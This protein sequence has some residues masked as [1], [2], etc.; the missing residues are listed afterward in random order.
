MYLVVDEA[1]TVARSAVKRR[2]ENVQ[3]GVDENLKIPREVA[4]DEVAAFDGGEGHLG[5]VHFRA[6]RQ[7]GDTGR[8]NAQLLRF[9]IVHTNW[10][11]SQHSQ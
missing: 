5:G 2:E 6:M 8:P 9:P 1:E 4:D 11:H 10:Q 3:R 7:S